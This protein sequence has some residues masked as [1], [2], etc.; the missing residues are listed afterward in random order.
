MRY[1]ASRV[2]LTSNPVYAKGLKELEER[3]LKDYGPNAQEILD[4]P[5]G[6][7]MLF[8]GPVLISSVASIDAFE[9]P[10]VWHLSLSRV[11]GP[12]APGRPPDN[13]TTRICK[14]FFKGAYKEGPPEGVFKTVRH[15][16]APWQP[17]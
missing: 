5:R 15:F 9:E 17:D 4:D 10:K 8:P 14:A 7:V 2:L 11:V 12:P 1:G 13:I 6:G 3:F 16:R